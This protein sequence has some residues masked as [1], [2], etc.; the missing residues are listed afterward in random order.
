MH[1]L[2]L[3]DERDKAIST[4]AYAFN[5]HHL[6]YYVSSN[7]CWQIYYAE[8]KL[9]TKGSS[10]FPLVLSP[11]KSLNSKALRAQCYNDGPFYHFFFLLQSRY[12]TREISW[13]T[14]NKSRVEITCNH[15]DCN[16]LSKDLFQGQAC[17]SGSY[18]SNNV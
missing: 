14:L 8:I 9:S 1:N 12:H 18:P 10:R 6:D 7:Y 5:G 15:S 2:D 4:R 17:M 13:Y 3:W 11:M 16:L